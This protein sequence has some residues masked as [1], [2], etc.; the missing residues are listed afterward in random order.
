M[1]KTAV[2]TGAEGFIGSHMAR[3]L[4]AKGWQVIGLHLQDAPACASEAAE[5]TICAM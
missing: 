2:V 3:F 1:T 4:Q 5:S